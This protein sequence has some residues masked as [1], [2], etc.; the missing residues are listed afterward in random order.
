MSKESPSL[1]ASGTV[2]VRTED[3]RLVAAEVAVAR[4][5]LPRLLGLMGRSRLAPE[6]GLWLLPCN[7]VHMFFMRTPLDVVYL[8]RQLRVVR[9]VPQMRE[10]SVKWLPV[11][12]AHSALELA[13]GTLRQRPLGPGD[14]IRFAK[15]PAALGSA[16]PLAAPT[17][18]SSSVPLSGSR[19]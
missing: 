2:T 8:D 5:F 15:E 13:P 7:S 6:E 3:G 19:P 9:C 14:Q 4:G 12:H 18:P 11:R 1:P 10:W 16:P 17:T